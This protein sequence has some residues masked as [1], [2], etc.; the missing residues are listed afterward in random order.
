MKLLIDLGLNLALLILVGTL[1]VGFSIFLGKY[2]LL[3]V[4]LILVGAS[5]L[6]SIIPLSWRKTWECIP[7]IGEGLEI[8]NKLEAH[9]LGH[10]ARS[11]FYYLLYPITS[12]FGFIFG[13]PSARRELS[14]YFHLIRW[15]MI[16]LII[17]SA[18][19]YYDLSQHFSL[20]FT[21]KWLYLE[22]L[23][24][25][26]LANFFNNVPL[27]TFGAPV[28]PCRRERATG[29]RRRGAW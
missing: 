26:F 24:L 23:C 25:Y 21:L 20:I 14:A 16:L 27:L 13:G 5:S 22:L 7:V 3:V 12:I 1:F 18:T 2:E 6:R 29:L 11:V 4:A 9:Y 15:L 19:I 17:E 28:E 8:F 10:Q